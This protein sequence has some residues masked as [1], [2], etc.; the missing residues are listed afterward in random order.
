MK[1]QQQLLQGIT[2]T[3]DKERLGFTEWIRSTVL[4]LNHNLWRRCQRDMTDLLY[5][6]IE[7]ND[8]AKESSDGSSTA[9]TAFP[10]PGHAAT[11]HAAPP[12]VNTEPY[13]PPPGQQMWQPPPHQWPAQ[14]SNPT[15]VWGTMEP[16]WMQQQFPTMNYQSPAP[17]SQGRSSSAPATIPTS[18]HDVS[19]DINFS[20][21][22]SLLRSLNTPPSPRATHDDECPT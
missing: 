6:Y 15:S 3:G 5:R 8:A 20:G 9:S 21:S 12:N 22:S 2:P 7:M 17:E 16:Q 14:V 18:T 1:L 4:S 10:H 11:G 13:Q 19:A